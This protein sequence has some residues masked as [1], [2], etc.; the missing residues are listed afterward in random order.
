MLLWTCY[1]AVSQTANFTYTPIGNSYCAPATINFTSQASSRP[2]GY[3]WSF[4]NGQKSNQANPRIVFRAG[5]YRVHL[6]I[7]YEKTTASIT[8]E[9][10]VKPTDAVS[11][12]SDKEKLCSPGIV[13][14]T[15]NTSS[16]PSNFQW[17]FGDNSSIQNTT[18]PQLSHNFNTTGSFTTSVT[19]SNTSGCKSKSTL[20][21][22]I[23][24]PEVSAT[25]TTAD[26]CVPATNDFNAVVSVINNSPVATYNWNFGDG[27]IISTQQASITHIYGA[28][29][30]Y[31]PKLS[32]ATTDG[33][34]STFNFDSVKYGTPPTNLMAYPALQTF[35]GSERVHFIARADIA[36]EYI[37]M[38]GN[39]NPI[40][41]N[42]TITTHKFSSL[43]N[44]TIKVTS[45]QNNCPGDTI[46][47]VVNV[48][49][50]IAKFSYQNTCDDKRTFQFSNTSAG[51]RLTYSWDFGDGSTS[52][53]PNPTNTFPRV[54]AF[55]TM[56][57]V[58]DTSSS[59]SD[60]ANITIYTATPM[61]LNSARSICINSNTIFRIINNYSNSNASQTWYLLSNLIGPNADSSQNILATRLGNYNNYVVIDNGISYCADTLFLD[62]QI[63]VKGPNVNFTADNN[64]CLNQPVSLNNLSSSYIPS[65]VINSFIWNFGDSSALINAIQPGF[66]NY[67]KEGNYTIS[68]TAI[69]NNG[70][71]DTLSKN[72]DVRPMPFIWIMP[73]DA[74]YC[75]GNSDTLI[76]YTSDD[77][78][79][80]TSIPIQGLCNNCDSSFI[81][82]V[83]SASIYATV[84]NSYNCISSDSIFIKV[85]EPFS[86]TAIPD[87]VYVC[88]KQIAT[89][90]VGPPNK[91]VIWNPTLEL[92]N[93]VSYS[94]VVSASATRTYLATLT[95]SAG[96]F[97]SS[98]EITVNLKSNAEVDLPSTLFLPY[99]A[100]YTITPNY[101]SNIVS[102]LWS[103]AIGLNCSTCMFPQTTIDGT[104]TYSLK[105]TTDSGCF[106][107]KT[108][109]LV[110]ECNNAYLLM[111]TAFTPNNDGTNDVYYPLSFGIKHIKRFAIFNRA[112]Q[113]VFERR[114]FLPNERPSGWDGK[115]KNADQPMGTYI[116]IIEADCDLGQTTF[117]KG[118]FI[119]IR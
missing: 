92:D 25:Y 14:F 74:M 80:R 84:K 50:A 100:N 77:I 105:A 73:R 69:D 48:I 1:F 28:A 119:L 109:T 111:P 118:S 63:V 98:K 10:I 3:L 34:T 82:A 41:V 71:K 110:V 20:I 60:S 38:F 37:W 114:N 57:K 79:W 16:T 11:L 42:D 53:S 76:G 39:N 35:C 96:C 27:N 101:S 72:I 49:G 117:K 58:V 102:A 75:A 5:T 104:K 29:G 112:S 32:I 67:P 9:I 46:S 87:K 59:C 18:V 86:A 51:R 64:N 103:P 93:P 24:K 44:K 7:V 13:N 26:G 54:G 91:K 115:F 116:Y 66:Y 55:N 47:M 65:D 56:L 31:L 90:Q 89:L 78:L 85:F 94:P 33:C 21:V 45:K 99:N 107:T 95:D 12:S 43:G 81:T 30:N 17:D 70:C 97:S 8:K 19:F 113:L 52:N 83:H 15:A 36:D 108:I 61:L 40:A 106:I 88:E 62:H 6:V 23:K 4:G 68:L 22:Q 2:V